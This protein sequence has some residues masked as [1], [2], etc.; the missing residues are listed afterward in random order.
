MYA[1]VLYVKDKT[2]EPLG[3][4]FVN[5]TIRSAVNSV[6]FYCLLIFATIFIAEEFPSISIAVFVYV[7]LIITFY[8]FF[9]KKER[10]EKTFGILIKYLVPKRL[11]NSLTK[12][13]ETFYNDFPKIKDLIVPFILNL[14]LQI[15]MYI[16][17]YIIAISLGI[18]VPFYVIFVFFSIA[19][20]TATLPISVGG[21]GVREGMLL[22]L[23]TPFGIEMEKIIVLSLV[24]FVI[25]SGIIAAI[26]GSIFAVIEAITA[27]Q[28]LT[29]K[30]PLV[31]LSLVKNIIMGP[32]SRK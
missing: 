18:N 3:K 12:F 19:A 25:F 32:I 2:N 13:T 31:K 8:M 9:M 23:F 11:K 6:A 22:F 17:L 1:K 29:L 4:L 24:N 7:S 15:F 28:K 5:V 21:L 16:Q 30:R 10:G 27:K 14:I 20:I 26:Y